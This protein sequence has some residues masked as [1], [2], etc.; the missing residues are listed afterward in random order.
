MGSHESLE[1]KYS[2]KDGASI[3]AEGKLC[4]EH[5]ELIKKYSSA[6]AKLIGI[7]HLSRI[8]FFLTENSEII[9]NEINT[10][11]GF[12]KDSLYPKLIERAGISPAEA[13]NAM[14]CEVAGI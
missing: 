3:S 6:L 1:R 10:F 8:D 5:T 13:L 14:L 7:R 4:P 12:T 11:P 2:K 9:F